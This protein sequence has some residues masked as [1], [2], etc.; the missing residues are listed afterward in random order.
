LKP[1]KAKEFDWDEAYAEGLRLFDDD[2]DQA[3]TYADDMKYKKTG[4]Y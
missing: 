4:R 1:I 2:I 3:E